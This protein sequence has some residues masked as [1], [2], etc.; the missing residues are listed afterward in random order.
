MGSTVKTLVPRLMGSRE[1]ASR[2]F[3]CLDDLLMRTQTVDLKEILP[4]SPFVPVIVLFP[5]SSVHGQR[6][7][8]KS[9]DGQLVSESDPPKVL[10]IFPESSERCEALNLKGEFSFGRVTINFLEMSVHCEGEPVMLT[11]MQFKALEY[12]VQNPRRVISRDEFL[13]EVWGYESYPRTR[14]VDNHVLRLRQK[15]ERDPSR[16]V[17]FLTIHG[18][19][20]KFLP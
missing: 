17:H 14:T 7:G 2:F 10:R 18:A 9:L 4:L 12:F 11:T 3:L 1:P 20:Y 15:L 8:A 19:G 16:P 13:N 6:P 5:G